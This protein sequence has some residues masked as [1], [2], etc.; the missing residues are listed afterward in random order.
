MRIVSRS[1]SR[2]RSAE[3]AIPIR[4]SAAMRSSAWRRRSSRTARRPRS[5]RRLRARPRAP[6][7]ATTRSRRERDAEPAAASRGPRSRRRSSRR[8]PRAIARA[9]DEADAEAA[10]A[11]ARGRLLLPEA[12]EDVREELG[13]DPVALVRD[14]ELEPA[15]LRALHRHVAP[16]RPDGEN[17]TPFA[18]RFQSD[19]LEARRGR[20]PSRGRSRS[21]WHRIATPRFAAPGATA[22][23]AAAIVSESAHALRGAAPGR[24]CRSAR[25]R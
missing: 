8:A 25:G 3:R 1:F 24:S 7:G 17:F 6:S 15:V 22:S 9:I 14:G 2:S 4:F 10:V 5:P 16:C 12:L 11:A 21:M 13:L 23:S 19:L 20:P 18:R